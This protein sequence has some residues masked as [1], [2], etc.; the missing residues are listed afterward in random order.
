[1]TKQEYLN[2]LNSSV[3]PYLLF[4]NYWKEMKPPEYRELEFSEFMQLMEVFIENFIG[5]PVNTPSGVK[6]V[7]SLMQMTTKVKEYYDNKFGIV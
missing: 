5:R 6:Q 7:N 3:V 1:M 2:D 4:F